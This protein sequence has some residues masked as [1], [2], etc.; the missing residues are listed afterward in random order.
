VPGR[1]NKATVRALARQKKALDLRLA[2]LSFTRI[3]AKIGITRQR[4]HQLVQKGLQETRSQIAAAGDEVRA[5]ELARLDGMLE[6]FYPMATKGDLQAGD[7]VLKI[8]ERRAKLLGLEAPV[9]IETT[10]RDGA[11]IEVSSSVSID[12]S[13]LSTATLRELLD[14]RGKPDGG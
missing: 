10:G 8:G 2:G 5:E 4:A 6:K 1:T 13:K 11:A 14:A 3:G 12:P 7:R 9:R